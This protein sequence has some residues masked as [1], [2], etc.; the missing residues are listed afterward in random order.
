M[1]SIQTRLARKAS[2]DMLFRGPTITAQAR[3]LREEEPGDRIL[4]PIRDDGAG[5]PLFLV[6]PVGGELLCYV[7]LST[8]L[9]NDRP[10]LG[11]RAPEARVFGAGEATLERMAEVYNAELRR[12]LPN[13]PYLLAGWST[14]GLLAFEMARQLGE[15]V[16]L[17]A[18]FDTHPPAGDGGDDLPV[19]V[20]FAGE[21]GRLMGRDLIASRDHFEGL[22][23]DAQRAVLTEAMLAEG[24]LPPE[25]WA[26]EFARMLDVFTRN[27]VAVTGYRMRRTGRRLALFSAAEAGE[28]AELTR[29][30][31]PWAGGGIESYPALG[32][33]HSILR[34]PHVATVAD[35]LKRCLDRVDH[36]RREG[37][38]TR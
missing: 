6:H 24:I 3:A 5:T 9:G 1:T 26:E 32:D 31:E 16:G 2:L 30:W 29:R 17:V 11:I 21:M 7:E 27:S 20:R 28:P 14:G 10:L 25:D 35:Q 22:D 37:S 36:P 38:G 8:A 12:V 23:P 19:L 34:R 15:S 13:G 33:H 4:V 18:L